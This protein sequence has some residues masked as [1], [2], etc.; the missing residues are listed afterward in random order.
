MRSRK[1]GGCDGHGRFLKAHFAVLSGMMFIGASPSSVGGGIR[2]TTFA[3]MILSIF[4]LPAGKIQLN[5]L[6][7][8]ST[9]KMNTG[10][11]LS[12]QQ[13]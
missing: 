12:S 13:R 2:T 5:Y 8:I 7:A 6:A 10:R 11:L 9:Q 1:K 4:S 3:I